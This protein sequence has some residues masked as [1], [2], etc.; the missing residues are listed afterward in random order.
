MI[1]AFQSGFT[2]LLGLCIG[3]TMG[4]AAFL[5]PQT[6][7]ILCLGFL[8]ICLDTVTGVLFGQIRCLL[9]KGQINPLIGAAGISV[10]PMAAGIM[11]S[12]LKDMG[13]G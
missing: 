9:T 3:A 6:L 10:Y 4:G 2:L 8:A 11:L 5:K 7:L 13:L 12:I 1:D